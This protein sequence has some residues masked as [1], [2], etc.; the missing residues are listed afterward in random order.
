MR[1]TATA[2]YL[3][4]IGALIFGEEF[5]DP[6]VLSNGGDIVSHELTHAV[7]AHK[8]PSCDTQNDTNKAFT[9]GT[10]DFVGNYYYVGANA[11]AVQERVDYGVPRNW[12]IP[13]SINTKTVLPY[14]TFEFYALAS[15]GKNQPFI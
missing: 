15:E 7:Q 4:S 6:P 2:C 3:P 9:E 11:A 5:D 1:H 10:A 8:C 12:A 14:K 13:L